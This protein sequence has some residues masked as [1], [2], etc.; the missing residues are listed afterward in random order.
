MINPQ[1]IFWHH[2]LRTAR[3]IRH[4]S[5]LKVLRGEVELARLA[6]FARGLPALAAERV[7]ARMRALRRGHELDR[8]LDLL[9]D[10]GKR[11]QFM[12]SGGEPLRAELET[13]GWP[14]AAARWPNV[15]F[16]IIPG[17]DHI[18]RPLP[19]QRFVHGELDSALEAELGRP[20]VRSAGSTNT[21]A[22]GASGA[23]GS[24]E[25][26]EQAPGGS[27]VVQVVRMMSTEQG[28]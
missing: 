6:C 20:L 11:V 15:S 1:A 25:A 7:G 10:G 24:L 2:S 21:G 23:D 28:A 26:T 13:H 14:G 19:A 12:F 22:M 5:K 16:T 3:M 27:R 8:A 9:R 18:L 4:G 17:E